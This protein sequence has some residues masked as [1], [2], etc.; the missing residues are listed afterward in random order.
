MNTSNIY[1]KSFLAALLYPVTQVLWAIIIMGPFVLMGV[2]SNE[3]RNY[4]TIAAMLLSV[5]STCLFLW[6]KKMLRIP[7][8]FDPRPFHW[9]NAC[10]AIVGA[11]VCIIATDLLNE[12]LDLP[13][14]S[15]QE[16]YALVK[17]SG[18]ALFLGIIGPIAEELIFRE[19]A[20]GAMLRAGIRPW[21]AIVFSAFLFG[22][23]HLNP[24]QIF[25]A[26]I[27]GLMLG[28]IYHC[29]RN[30]VLVSIIHIANNSF[31]VEEMLRLGEDA[32]DFSYAEWMGLSGT[33][34]WTLIAV[35]YVIGIVLLY[36][37]WRR[38]KASR[39]QPAT[40]IADQ[41]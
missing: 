33:A 24:A 9:S 3:F 11:I 13:N 5:I 34:L 20:E 32:E 22:I 14:I 6:W 30:I 12:Q 16:M 8:T 37:Y 40:E 38:K 36:H 39:P 10:L 21:K 41:N 29:T 18:G 28:F 7:R 25:F 17:T 15:E 23:I 27:A 1:L 4:A 19:G 31:S 26:F 35:L 2:A